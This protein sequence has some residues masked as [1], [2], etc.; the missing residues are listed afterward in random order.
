MDDCFS[1]FKVNYFEFNINFINKFFIFNIRVVGKKLN[2][3]PRTQLSF[4]HNYIDEIIAIDPP[5]ASVSFKCLDHEL[6][7]K[8]SLRK[9]RQSAS[10]IRQVKDEEIEKFLR[11]TSS[12][13]TRSQQQQP[14][15]TKK[16]IEKTVVIKQNSNSGLFSSA[17][18]LSKI[19]EDDK[20]VDSISFH[21]DFEDKLIIHSASQSRPILDVKYSV[22]RKPNNNSVIFDDIKSIK[23]ASKLPIYADISRFDP[24]KVNNKPLLSSKSASIHHQR[25]VN[26]NTV[27][28]PPFNYDL[29]YPF[30]VRGYNNQK[31]KLSKH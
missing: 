10:G 19:N 2:L 29:D 12:G 25:R 24:I 26:I 8:L 20:R 22:F 5:L 21:R 18:R 16:T 17:K 9:A 28:L 27:R 4:D 13:V 6:N 14:A 15:T 23:S 31:T 7:E 3:P 30:E 1:T 11:V